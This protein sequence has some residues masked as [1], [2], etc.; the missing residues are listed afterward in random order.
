MKSAASPPEELDHVDAV[1]MEWRLERSYLDQSSTALLSRLGRLN[2]A[3]SK[4]LEALLSRFNITRA[5]YDV[6]ATLRR[7]GAPFSQP[8]QVLLKSLMRTSGTMTFRVDRL[9]EKG[10]V[11]RDTDPHD[12]RGILVSLTP[13]G[14]AL[15]DSI[16]PLHLADGGKLLSCLTTA[17][18][19]Q[20]VALLKKMLLV[21]ERGQ[22]SG[23]QDEDIILLQRYGFHLSEHR[24]NADVSAPR[25]AHVIPRS[26]ADVAGLREKEKL[27]RINGKTI[28]STK[29]ALAELLSHSSSD[30]QLTVERNQQQLLITLKPHDP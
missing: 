28:S 19:G 9:E 18:H 4:E 22:L 6:L 25:I 17:E 5:E 7:K 10:L 12:R 29:E 27:V 20:F 14:E 11:R 3:V 21:A 2:I 15:F 16:Q 8:I 23:L 30:L 1:L 13:K 24:Q 26:C